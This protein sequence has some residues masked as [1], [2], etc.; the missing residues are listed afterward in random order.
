MAGYGMKQ[1]EDIDRRMSRIILLQPRVHCMG[2]MSRFIPASVIPPFPAP[3]SSPSPGCGIGCLCQKARSSRSSLFPHMSCTFSPF[4][5][6][7]LSF[8]STDRYRHFPSYSFLSRLLYFLL[9]SFGFVGGNCQSA[10]S[11]KSPRIFR[12]EHS[13]IFSYPAFLS[14]LPYLFLHFPPSPGLSF[15]V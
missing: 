14:I 5:I 11:R 4:I 12:S 7:P 13:T 1:E 8:S 6:P 15:P 9:H 3:A 10:A 2:P